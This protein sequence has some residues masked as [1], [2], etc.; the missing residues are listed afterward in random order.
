MKKFL[1]IIIVLTASFVFCSCG[2]SEPEQPTA[3]EPT[4]IEVEN[5][6]GVNVYS[7]I[8][9]IDNTDTEAWSGY[10]TDEINVNTAVN[11]I[12]ECMQRDDWTDDSVV[13]GYAKEALLKNMMYQYGYNGIDGDYDSIKLYQVGVYNDDYVLQGELD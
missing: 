8:Y 12:K 7:V 5:A 13:Y 3:Y 9:D 2:S 4:A 6:D 1:I 10:D 11:G